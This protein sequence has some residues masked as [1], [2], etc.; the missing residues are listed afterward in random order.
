MTEF[1]FLSEHPF[2]KKGH[3]MFSYFHITQIVIVILLM[4]QKCIISF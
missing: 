4:Q 2:K 1:S 3:Y